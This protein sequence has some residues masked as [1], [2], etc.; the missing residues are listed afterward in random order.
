MKIEQKITTDDGRPAMAMHAPNKAVRV[1]I[2]PGLAD[3]FRRHRLH[4]D[5]RSR[6]RWKEGDII[7]LRREARIEPYSHIL[8]G[9]VLPMQLGAFS[10]SWGRIEPNMRIGRY[11]SIAATVSKLGLGHPTNWVSSSPFSHN[12]QPLGA[13]AAYFGDIGL[14]KFPLHPF[15]QGDQPITIGHDVWIGEGALLK[16]GV[17]IGD[18][19]I[20][21]ARAIVTHDVPP[22]A[23]V[24]GVPARLI[25]YRF[26]ETIADRLRKAQ[27]WRFGPEV[28]QSM[29]VRE[30]E[31]FLDRFEQA[32]AAGLKELNLPILT[33]EDIIAAGE[34]LS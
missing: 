30:P 32:V 34:A 25:R 7:S 5:E 28:V 4:S 15:D 20:V 27:W 18:G 10:Y 16:A 9:M 23:I 8:E 6:L 21:A 24:G 13:F 12:P 33:G 31:A 1:R 3:I 19:A 22:Y 2:T 17:S 29:D 11:C 14:S 26:A